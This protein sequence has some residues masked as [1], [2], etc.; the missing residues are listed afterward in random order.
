[1]AVATQGVTCH[2]GPASPSALLL[3][4]R[5]NTCI[6]EKRSRE[7]L[8]QCPH[9]VGAQ[10]AAR[11]WEGRQGVRVRAPAGGAPEPADGDSGLASVP[12]AGGGHRPVASCSLPTVGIRN[13]SA[14]QGL[15]AHVTPHTEL[16]LPTR[17]C[18]TCPVTVKETEAQ[19]PWPE[20][21]QSWVLAARH[22]ALSAE[23]GALAT[24]GGDPDV[25][26]APGSG[27]LWHLPG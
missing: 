13:P 12:C 10:R 7:A 18:S 3:P 16:T 21:R 17:C 23:L 25:P 20:V 9:G 1:M 24:D 19:S 2:I 11:L 5:P 6:P 27:C 26:Q 15:A 22:G 8:A 4:P 14:R